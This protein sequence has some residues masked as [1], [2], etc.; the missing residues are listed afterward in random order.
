MRRAVLIAAVLALAAAPARAAPP[1]GPPVVDARDG[2]ALFAANC[3]RCHGPAGAG[4]ATSADASL[5]GP[6]L[7]GVGALAA[8]FYLR[9]G[10]MP[11]ADARDQPVRGRQRL[12]EPAIRALTSYV[13]SLGTGR[14]S[15]PRTRGPAASPRGAS[16]SPATARAATRSSPRAAC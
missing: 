4:I 2:A 9:T 6:D 14:A 15:R 7:R 16:C 8:D 3:A 5:R 11:L 1:S 10:Y 13:A 12:S